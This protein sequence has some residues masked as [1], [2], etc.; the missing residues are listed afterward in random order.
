VT[1]HRAGYE[2]PA[3]ARPSVGA[4]ARVTR[5][6]ANLLV[7]AAIGYAAVVAVSITVPRFFGYQV[8]TV[9]SDSMGPTFRAGDLVVESKVSP[10]DVRLGDVV[11]YRKPGTK[12]TL[13]THRVVAIAAHGRLV[14]FRT[15][16]DANTGFEGWSIRADGKLGRV[17]YHVPKVGYA[18]D[19]IGSRLG[20]FA[21]VVVPALLLGLFELK[22]IWS[23]KPEA[24]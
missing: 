22:R 13:V 17:L 8:L 12:S 20:R 24:E 9:L 15:Q 5:R 16:G 19:R 23:R 11:T 2:L 1:S 4:A 18:T 6:V 10:L 3:T 21:L 14:S 7:M